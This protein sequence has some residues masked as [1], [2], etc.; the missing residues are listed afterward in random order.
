MDK[1]KLKDFIIDSMIDMNINGEN[2][3]EDEPQKSGK[4]STSV[5]SEEVKQENEPTKVIKNEWLQN[6]LGNVDFKDNKET[7]DLE[8]RKDAKQQSGSSVVKKEQKQKSF[9]GKEYKNSYIYGFI[10]AIFSVVFEIAGM[11]YLN[12]GVI[13]SGF[14]MGFGIIIIFMG[15]IFIVPGKIL[16]ISL[17]TLLIIFQMICNILNAGS[18]ASTGTLFSLGTSQMFFDLNATMLNVCIFVC[19]IAAMILCSIFMPKYKIQKNRTAVAALISLLVVVVGTGIG[20]LSFAGHSY[21]NLEYEYIMENNNYIYDGSLSRVATYKKY[22]TFCYFGNMIFN[23]NSISNDTKTDLIN[24]YSAD[25]NYKYTGSTWNDE[26]VS[27]KLK[28]DNLIIISLEGFNGI[29]LDP[30]NTPNLYS[31]INNEAITTNNFY[32][33]AQNDALFLGS[34][35]TVNFASQDSLKYG[36]ANLFN[37]EEYATTNIVENSPKNNQDNYRAYGFKNVYYSENNI[38]NCIKNEYNYLQENIKKIALSSGK[39]FSYYKTSKISNNLSESL[40]NKQDYDFFDEN[41]E[42]Y[43]NYLI[44]NNINFKLP[45]INSEEYKILR[46]YKCRATKIDS[47]FNLLLIY[48]KTHT[49]GGINFLD[50][51]SVIVV[52]SLAN[53]EIFNMGGYDNKTINRSVFS[54]PFAIYNKKLGNGKL[55]QIASTLN[56]Y[57]SICDL[58]GF[59]H[60]QFLCADNSIF[61]DDKNIYVSNSVAFNEDFYTFAYDKYISKDESLNTNTKLI[62]FKQ[63]LNELLQKQYDINNYYNAKLY[64]E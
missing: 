35:Q 45:E 43:K 14:G 26:I 28:G 60:N 62:S 33:Y 27:E 4:V 61:A 53:G 9:L 18:V 24:K 50:N 8:S 47:A 23:T 21:F 59:S 36:I 2:E 54:V 30:Y 46:E 1:S 29:A 64:A 42:N 58:Y 5:S 31:F 38:N 40:L 7:N 37:G 57:S 51:T 6:N 3:S 32:G 10:F 19:F 20:I 41:F 52:G 63:K 16:K 12:L 11:A 48:L 22:G 25:D 55:N 49:N 34:N 39:F 15:A 17:T 56:V 13:P 44:D